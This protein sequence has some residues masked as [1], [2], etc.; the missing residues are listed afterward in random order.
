MLTVLP[1][2]LR[3]V[4]KG[5]EKT[6]EELAIRGRIETP[7]TVLL[8]SARLLSR[9]QETPGDFQSFRLHG[10]AISWHCCED[11]TR[12]KIIIIV[13]NI[14]SRHHQTEMKEKNK[15]RL[16]Q[17]NKKSSRNKACPQNISKGISL[18]SKILYIIFKIHI[19]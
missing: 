11:L 3:T 12:N 7:T 2:A 17:K 8:R 4:A 16:P 9:V 5:S 10:R 6:Q 15:K 13:G 14:G 18:P 19:R 1:I